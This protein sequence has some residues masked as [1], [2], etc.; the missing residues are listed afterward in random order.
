MPTYNIAHWVEDAIRSILQQSYSH[1]ELILVDDGSNDNTVGKIKNV[2][3]PRIK[4]FQIEHQGLFRALNIGIKHAKGEWI[5]RMDGDDISHPD[6]LR[7]Q[8]DLLSTDPGTVICG[9]A[10]GY[11]SPNGRVVQKDYGFE[12][13][14]LTVSRIT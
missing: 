8:I 14:E 1:F 4:L 13:Q 2:K 12:T 6:R 9:T 5:A 7:K 3:D 11:V 10:F